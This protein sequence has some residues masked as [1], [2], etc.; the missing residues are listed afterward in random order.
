[1]PKYRLLS[2]EELKELEKEF[3]DYL[4]V[5]GI[6][7]DDWGKIKDEDSSKAAQIIELFSDVVFEGIMRKVKFLEL[8]TRSEL[9]VFQ[10]LA[11]KLVL[12]G[13]SAE[14]NQEVDFTNPD[15]VKNAMVEPPSGLKVYTSEKPYEDKREIELFKIIQAGGVIVDDRLFKSLC[16][17]L[18]A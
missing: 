12:V 5:N 4:V 2:L 16:M 14:P 1:M 13:M 17:A 10:C 3:I 15:F 8:R 18:S 6:T 11:D 9:K 7:A